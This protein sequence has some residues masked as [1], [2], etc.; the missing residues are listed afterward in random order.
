MFKKIKK[1]GQG[2]KLRPYTE[3]VELKHVLLFCRIQNYTGSQNLE[4]MVKYFQSQKY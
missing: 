1:I 3:C 2:K 4:N